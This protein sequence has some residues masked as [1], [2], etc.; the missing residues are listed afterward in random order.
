MKCVLIVAAFLTLFAVLGTRPAA[1]DEIVVHSGQGFPVQAS[2]VLH[3]TSADP[4]TLAGPT[5]TVQNLTA[6]PFVG[7]LTFLPVTLPAG[8]IVTSAVLSYDF[9]HVTALNE[10]FVVLNSAC[11]PSLPSGQCA[12]D[13]ASPATFKN[14]AQWVGNG[15]SGPLGPLGTLNIP[16]FNGQ[17]PEPLGIHVIGAPFLSLDQT[18]I[19]ALVSNFGVDSVTDAQFFASASM[20]EAALT[21]DFT[22]PPPTNAPEPSSLALLGCALA[23]IGGTV[24]VRRLP[25]LLG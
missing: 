2:F 6:T 25:Q 23:V 7:E 24:F 3:V 11:L 14:L 20:G 8:S 15:G 10:S 18:N 21:I 13:G 1:A 22:P 16:I 9:S 4:N 5:V 17:N 12:Q 19:G